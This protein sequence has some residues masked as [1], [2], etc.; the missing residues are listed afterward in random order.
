VICHQD[1]GVNVAA[2]V[3]RHFVEE[4]QIDEIVALLVKTGGPIVST[5]DDVEGQVGNSKAGM[6]GHIELTRTPRNGRTGMLVRYL[7][8]V[9]CPRFKPAEAR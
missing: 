6:A 5:L 7:K 3:P 2:M 1:I 4:V 8:I 9:V